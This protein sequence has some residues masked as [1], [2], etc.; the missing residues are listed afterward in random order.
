M[1]GGETVP[2][3]LMYVTY[4]AQQIYK[5]TLLTKMTVADKPP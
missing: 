3:C 4:I 2:V 5:R 1:K